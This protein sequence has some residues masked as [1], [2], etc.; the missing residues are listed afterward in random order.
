MAGHPI[1]NETQ[2]LSGALTDLKR[3]GGSL[4]EAYLNAGTKEMLDS[5]RQVILAKF[6]G[7]AALAIA[8]GLSA[9]GLVFE[10]TGWVIAQLAPDS[11]PVTRRALCHAAILAT[12]AIG[13]AVFTMVR[14]KPARR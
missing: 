11:G 8:I 6:S 5:S 1:A 12:F 2:S 9:Y 14:H 3:A 10:L 4:L 13:S 7:I